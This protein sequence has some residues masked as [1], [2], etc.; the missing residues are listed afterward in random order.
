VPTITRNPRLRH[1]YQPSM[2][3]RLG[4]QQ[5]TLRQVFAGLL[6]VQLCSVELGGAKCNGRHAEID[7]KIKA[8]FS[9]CLRTRGSGVR[10]SPGAPI[11]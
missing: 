2:M 1:R 5:P 6:R 7:N 11:N 9:W 10:I 8:Q 4:S 3:S